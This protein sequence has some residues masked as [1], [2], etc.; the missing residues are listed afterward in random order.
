LYSDTFCLS[1]I[2]HMSKV[3]MI[4]YSG[5]ISMSTRKDIRKYF[6]DALSNTMDLYHLSTDIGLANGLHAKPPYIE[7][8]KHPEFIH[9]K[10]YM[11]GLN[12]F[13][14]KRPLNSIEISHLYQNISTN[15]IGLKLCLSFAQTSQIE[16]VQSYMLRARDISKKHITI[17]VD[18]LL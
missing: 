16:E 4:T 18:A 8:P 17:F 13:S 14:E 5:F 9:S 3:G 10:N 15:S 1:Y 2:N 7:T 11:G 6:S 12:P